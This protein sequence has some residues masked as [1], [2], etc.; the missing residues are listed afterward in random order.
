MPTCLGVEH[1]NSTVAPADDI[2]S[3][4]TVGDWIE[5]SVGNPG[6]TTAGADGK[7]R[8]NCITSHLA[9]DDPI[10][11]PSQP[12]KAHLHQF[13][14]NTLTNAHSTYSTLRTTG[15]GTCEGGPINRTGYWHPAMIRPQN[16]RVVKPSSYTIYYT[17]EHFRADI[18]NTDFGWNYAAIMMPR[19]FSFIAGWPDYLV[20]H[21]TDPHVPTGTLLDTPFK[22][23]ATGTNPHIWNVYDDNGNDV[24]GP[25]GTFEDLA[26]MCIV[27]GFSSGPTVADGD[28]LIGRFE[29]PTCWD[30]VNL[31]SA[32]GR[33]HVTYPRQGGGQIGCPASHPHALAEVLFGLNFDHQGHADFRQWYLSSD[34]GHGAPDAI[35]PGGHTMHT[36][37]FGAWDQGVVDTFS[38]RVL[39]LASIP[40]SVFITCDNG[41]LNNDTKL[42][43]GHLGDTTFLAEGDGPGFRYE[44]IPVV[45]ST[46]VLL[47]QACM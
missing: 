18:C 46:V 31:T 47:G 5:A 20:G 24:S 23:Q 10:L 39:G 16:N 27:T 26:D 1:D 38:E 45:P 12:G 43:G 2:P 30:G 8:I 40:G 28:K 42:E 4:F 7:F 32:T 25:A 3:N 41:G 33:T 6:C 17:V 9:Y 35:Y 13:F 34:N 22:K 19:G 44:L 36:D 21:P 15:S 29:M 14:G 11:Y 37:W